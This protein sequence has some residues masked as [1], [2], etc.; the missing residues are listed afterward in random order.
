MGNENN[1]KFS[2]YQIVSAQQTQRES[3]EKKYKDKSKKRLATIISTKIKTSFIGS[4]SVCEN[5]FGFLWGHGKD[6]EELTEQEAAVR[7]IWDEVRTQI[8]DNGNT[9]LRAAAS[10]MNNYS[11]SWDRYHLD[12]P[13]KE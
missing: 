5:N 1:E 9:Q 13:V 7:E 2:H 6:V 4:I 3:K 11:I 10:E 12:I 8:L